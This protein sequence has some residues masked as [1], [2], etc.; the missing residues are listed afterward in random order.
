MSRL[1]ATCSVS[2]N[3]VGDVNIGQNRCIT[4]HSLNINF[5]WY[6]C[7][8]QSMMD[9]DEDDEYWSGRSRPKANIFGD[10]NEVRSIPVGQ[11]KEINKG[12]RSEKK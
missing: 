9:E 1:S 3:P 2:H 8:W 12:M 4:P 5:K 6:V 10:D 11:K 7:T